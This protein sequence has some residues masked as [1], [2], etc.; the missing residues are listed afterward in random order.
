MGVPIPAFYAEDGTA[1]LDENIIN[2]IATLF[3]QYGSN[4][5]YDKEAK[6]CF[7]KAI[8]IQEALI[9]SLLKKQIRWMF[10]L[11]QELVIKV[12]LLTWWR[13]SSRFVS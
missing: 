7:P 9:T 10:G 3:G 1:I 12:V 4:I 8:L 5:W 6:T 2:H 13:L 11:T